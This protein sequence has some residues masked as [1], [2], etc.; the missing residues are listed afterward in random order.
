MSVSMNRKG[1]PHHHF[2]PGERVDSVG[3]AL[4]MARA[5]DVVV[6]ATALRLLKADFRALTSGYVGLSGVTLAKAAHAAA[7]MTA[8]VLTSNV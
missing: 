3:F 2:L 7:L 6:A 5:A 8:C 4:G 1:G